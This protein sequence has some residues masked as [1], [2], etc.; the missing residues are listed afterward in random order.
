MSGRDAQAIQAVLQGDVDR[1][2]ELV[3][4]Y[5]DHALRVAFSFLGNHEDAKDVSQEAFIH[6]YRSLGQFRGG[7]KFS[8]WLYRIVVNLCK[9]ACKRRARRPL[10]V[11]GV[12]GT[13]AV[14][15]E[16]IGLFVEVEDPAADPARQASRRELSRRLTDAIGALPM[17]QR[18]AFLL[19]HVHGLPLDEVAAI[20]QC[21]VGTVKSHVFRATQH[22]RVALDPWLMQEGI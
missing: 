1:F 12:G 22:L 2:A 10:V 5:Q 13:D 4:R 9:D 3:D 21:R 16:D 17:N 19:H 8:T 18:S 6:A 7:A 11:A 15:D 20:M 14:S